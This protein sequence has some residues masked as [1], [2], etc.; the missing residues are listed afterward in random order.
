MI[1]PKLFIEYFEYSNP[2][3]MYKNLNKTIG[4]KENKAGGNAIKDGLANL[5]KEFNSMVLSTK[6]V[7]TRT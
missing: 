6:S 5:I 3:H 7:R 2:S 1:D 4:S